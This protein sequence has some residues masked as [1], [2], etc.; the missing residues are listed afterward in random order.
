MDDEGIST[1]K[2]FLKSIKKNRFITKIKIKKKVILPLTSRR[3][4]QEY[5]DKYVPPKRKILNN[6]LYMKVV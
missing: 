1:N 2:D 3:E 5:K 6:K 4:I